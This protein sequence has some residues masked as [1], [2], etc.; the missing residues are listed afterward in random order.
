MLFYL[1]ADFFY[2]EIFLPSLGALST[3]GDLS[4]LG[5]VSG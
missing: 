4:D 1:L 3:L 5:V 2:Y